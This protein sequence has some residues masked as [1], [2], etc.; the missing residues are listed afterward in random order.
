MSIG[1]RI[2]EQRKRNNLSQEYIAE[3]LEVSRQAVSKWERDLTNPDTGNLIK[4]AELL[5]VSVEYLATGKTEPPS[6]TEKP[7]KPQFH[8]KKK[9]ILFMAIALGLCIIIGAAVRIYTLPVAWDAGACGG[10]YATHIF[11][12]YSSKLVQK[13]LDGSQS[14]E[15][16]VS[17]QAVRGT[18]EATW[19]DRTIHLH[20]DIQYEHETNGTVTE[21]ITF[22]GTRYWFDS[23]KWGGAIIE[24]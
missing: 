22:I 12:K 23:Y 1:K 3:K 15:E 2:A 16:I 7:Q 4:L 18:Q 8:T 20:F 21:R 17:I 6:C 10:G 13:Y 9:Q 14:K 24:G 5:N 19:E 11:D